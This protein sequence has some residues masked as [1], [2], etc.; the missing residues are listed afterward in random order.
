MKK[1]LV[2]II[3][4]AVL[5]MSAKAY[6]K[7][8]STFENGTAEC[9]AS[10]DSDAAE[11][12]TPDYLSYKGVLPSET[13][14]GKCLGVKTDTA[15]VRQAS[16]G[17][18]V[19]IDNYFYIDMMAQFTPTESVN[20]E[21]GDK[22]ALYMNAENKLVVVAKDGNDAACDYATTNSLVEGTW[23]RITIRAFKT[24]SKTS[25]VVPGFVVYVNGV[26]AVAEETPA[27][28]ATLTETAAPYAT[29]KKLFRSLS[30]D[31]KIT[32][33]AL[34][35]VGKVDDIVFSETRGTDA[36]IV[37][38]Y[39]SGTTTYEIVDASGNKQVD[40]TTTNYA[41]L[42]TGVYQVKATNGSESQLV[43]TPV[44]VIKIEDTS[45]NA[46]IAVPW[47]S[48]DGDNVAVA[49]MFAS[50]NEDDVVSFYHDGEYRN[51]TY[52]NGAWGPDDK[53]LAA[54]YTADKTFAPGT[55]A[56]YKR[57][58]TE[59]PIVMVGTKKDGVS[60][61]PAAASGA[62]TYSAIGVPS[63]TNVV[64]ASVI[65]VIPEDAKTASNKASEAKDMIII[66]NASGK[67][68]PYFFDADGKLM[69]R[70]GR[71]SESVTIPAG[72]GFMYRATT[73]SVPTFTFE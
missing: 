68:E 43:G 26:E 67:F 23:Y 17:S 32:G 72:R 61:A 33:L 15:L 6:D 20:V 59:S 54:G 31:A 5:A 36:D 2:S 44:G 56:F 73:S 51:Y 11:Y 35:G 48:L 39:D 27:T 1:T 7:T 70:R 65:G 13:A 52:S 29:A 50:P 57:S 18:A 71:V 49:D 28:D 53:A 38:P 8:I 69:D 9:F 37:N 19:A 21:P 47:Q 16:G 66:Q 62:E 22:L 14:S 60:M 30:N 4:T 24:I 3:F 42:A 63:A 46:F 41:E 25:T 58:D 12:V 34:T 64:V 45:T 55:A 10:F 40:G